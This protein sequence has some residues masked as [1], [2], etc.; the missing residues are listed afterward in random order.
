MNT[1]HTRYNMKLSETKLTGIAKNDIVANFVFKK[2]F[3]KFHYKL[4]RNARI[5]F[6]KRI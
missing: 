2:V 6:Q 1:L 5:S 4:V 3:R